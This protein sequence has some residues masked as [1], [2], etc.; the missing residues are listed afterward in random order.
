[1][2]RS[3]PGPPRPAT[4]VNDARLALSFTAGMLA[5]VNPCAL[6]MLPAYLG[7]FISGDDERRPVGPTV[8]RAVVVAVAVSIGFVTVFGVLGAL[9]TAASAQVEEIT[10]WLTPIVGLAL[11]GLGLALLLGKVVKVPLPRLDGAGRGRGL[12][13]MF[14]YGASYAIVSV[15]CTLAIFLGHVSTTFGQS[16]TVGLTQLAAFAAGFA[17]VLVALSV[18]VAL[19]KG[20]FARGAR[21]VSAYAGRLAGR[22][23]HRHRRVP[24]LVRHLRAA[25]VPLGPRGRP[26]HRPGHRLV[27]RHLHRG[28]GRRRRRG[29]PGAGPV[30]R[31]RG[32][33]GRRPLRRRLLPRS[34]ST[35]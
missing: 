31:G 20:S 26:G 7:W 30:R 4:T 34:R 15:S 16:W 2:R 1:M 13:A 12:A 9:A 33:G 5:T 14:L 32:P 8:A 23:A 27:G 22:P 3:P 11:A 24:D 18:S 17:L 25:P 10:P 35:R 29:R 28:A 19:A 21:W 6:P